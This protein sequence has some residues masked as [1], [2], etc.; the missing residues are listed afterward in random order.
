M[1]TH[2][3]PNR[4]FRGAVP[5]F[6]WYVR[7]NRAN[8]CCVSQFVLIVTAK[9]LHSEEH[10]ENIGQWHKQKGRQGLVSDELAGT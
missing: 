6:G 10:R 8:A 4:R 9:V 2:L 5:P 1:G 7:K 3:A